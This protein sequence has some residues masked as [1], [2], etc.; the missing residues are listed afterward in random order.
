MNVAISDKRIESF[1]KSRDQIIEM[2][3]RHSLSDSEHL[4]QTRQRN[5]RSYCQWQDSQSQIIVPAHP[6]THLVLF[7]TEG[8]LGYGS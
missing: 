8:E 6:K 4:Q 5:K 1:R 7:E 2:A 3:C